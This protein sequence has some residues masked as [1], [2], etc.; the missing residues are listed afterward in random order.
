MPLPRPIR[1]SIQGEQGSFSEEAVGKLLDRPHHVV[2]TPDLARMFSTVGR[3]EA[4][5]CLAPMENSLVGSI[6]ESYDLLLQFGFRVLGEVYLRVEHCLI[7]PLGT[8]LEDVERV[9]SHPVALDQ[10]RT[11]FQRHPGL[12]AIATY[13]TAGSVRMLIRRRE[14]NAAAIAGRGAATHYGAKVLAENLEDDP[15]NYTRFFLLST[16]DDELQGIERGYRPDATGPV[17]TSIVFHV[18][19]EPGSL[20]R[21]LGG[22]AEAGVDL[23][24]IESRPVRGRPFEYLFYVDFFGEPSADPGRRALK[25]LGRRAGFLRTL[26]TYP[27]G[28]L[29]WVGTD[30]PLFPAGRARD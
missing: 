12:H 3:H 20:Y 30:A 7:A 24:K 4:H 25:A 18:T 14:A 27:S 6:F 26:G 17:K 15:A 1:V 23:A 10:C 29:D 22:F 9:Y 19:N 2:A 16:P 5:A 11:F 28:R 13:D 21:A 8:Y